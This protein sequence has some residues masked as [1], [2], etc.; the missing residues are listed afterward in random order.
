MRS[1]AA[2]FLLTYVVSWSLFAASSRLAG[3]GA[4]SSAFA[5]VS[6]AVLLLGVFAPSIVA[7]AL[8]TRVHGR[9]GVRALIARIGRVP[10]ARW[11][12]FALGYVVA[13]KFTA[14]LIHRVMIGEWPRFAID[15]AIL[16]PFAILVSTPVQAG[17]EIGWRGYALPRLAARMGW[18]IASVVL[19]VL[20]A[21]WHLWPGSMH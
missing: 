16:I 2:F 21:C 1:P 9:D 15:G 13:A 10:A 12:V 20:W 11:L 14:A 8:T 18:P 17:E 4:T 7:L 3:T 6:Q 19:G 5:G